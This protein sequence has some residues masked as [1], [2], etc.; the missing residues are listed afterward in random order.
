LSTHRS[1]H[2]HPTG[3]DVPPGGYLSG[4]STGLHAGVLIGT[5]VTMSLVVPVLLGG[6]RRWRALRRDLDRAMHEAGHDR[7]TGLPN[8]ATA[9]TLLQ[10]GG[11]HL[12]GLL[13]LD[14]FKTV[15]DRFGHH[16]GDQLLIH[17]A[18]RLQDA[19]AGQGTVA[20]YAGDEFLLLW[21]RPPRD[22]LATADSL[23][24]NVMGP[25][26]LEGHRLSPSASLGLALAGP[27]LRGP[28]LVAAADVAM[29]AAKRVGPVHLYADEFPPA[30]VERR[31]SGSRA[32]P[33]PRHD[34]PRAP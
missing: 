15:N 34:H 30:P 33:G 12:V 9:E 29:Y 1:R 23:L 19:I 26:Q 31:T 2:L 27:H 17:V 22:P 6:V 5:T 25:L 13:D 3:R 21:T 8:R 18:T 14:R 20:R 16:I 32:R 11:V 10:A 28:D 4:L 24:R 7:L